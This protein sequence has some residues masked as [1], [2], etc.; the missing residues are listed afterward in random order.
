MRRED[1]V[2]LAR[3]MKRTWHTDD[4][5]R[6]AQR[7][8]IVVLHRPSAVKDFKAQIIKA[9]GYPPIISIN[10]A[11]SDR[12]KRILCAHEL[13]HAILHE[14]CVNHFAT[15]SANVKTD[16]ELEANLFAV[17]LLADDDINRYLETPIE[18][19]NNYVLKYILDYNIG[20]IQ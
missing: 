4:P 14:N 5:Y 20:Q 10:E 1:I 2:N 18:Q 16:V 7:L 11:Y 6:I 15:T 19:M 8:G 3:E 13:G 17:A 9:E 12:A